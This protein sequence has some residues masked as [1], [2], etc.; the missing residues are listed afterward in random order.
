[1]T[2]LLTVGRYETVHILDF[3]FILNFEFFKQVDDFILGEFIVFVFIGLDEILD[4]GGVNS[5]WVIG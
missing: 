4:D 1:M 3:I 2:W 5:R